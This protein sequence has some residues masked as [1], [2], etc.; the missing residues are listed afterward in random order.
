MLN[1]L[2]K[3]E[4]KATARLLVPSYL[5]LICISIINRFL[6][7]SGN[8]GEIFKFFAGFLMVTHIAY[9]IIILIATV[10]F[11]TIR[12]YKNLL[13]DE[14]YL[15]FTLPVK[16][17]ELITSK[18]LITILWLFVSLIAILA[19][20]FIAFYN[21][22]NMRMVIE[23]TNKIFLTLSNAYGEH[24]ILFVIEIIIILLIST[25]ENILLIYVSIAVGQLFNKHKILLSFVSY[26]VIYNAI[27][28]LS[29]L[30]LFLSSFI[31]YGDLNSINKAPQILFPFSIV[32]GI[33]ECIAFYT[34]TNFIFKRKLNLE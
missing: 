29:F 19:S 28:L 23:T 13:S 8:K 1:K 21:S 2:M 12:F 24:Q 27:Q 11:M 7:Q 6:Y 16:T 30:L 15:M 32:F 5:V 10:L 3:H 31:I 25:F 33:I 22:S 9:I 17:H 26:A 34:A 4:L 18:L 14:G 20:L